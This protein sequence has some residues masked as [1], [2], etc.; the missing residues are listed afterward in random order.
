MTLIEAINGIDAVKPNTYDQSEKIRWLS[1]LDGRI[2]TEIID[3]HEGGDAVSFNGYT[4][5]T[6]LD[7]VLLVA[8]PYDEIYLLWLEAKIDYANKEYGKYNN[9]SSMYNNA[10]NDYWKYYNRTHLPISKQRKYF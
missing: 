1:Q 5:D 10:Y 7:R 9:S 3:T 8:A 6:P 2:K 4:E